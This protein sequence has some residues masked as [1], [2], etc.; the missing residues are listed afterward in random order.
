MKNCVCIVCGFLYEEAV[1][2]PA[3]GI[4][5]GTRWADAPA[6]RAGPYCDVTKA[7]FEVVEI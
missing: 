7:D 6:N 5:S 1:G 4:V 3:E 2:C